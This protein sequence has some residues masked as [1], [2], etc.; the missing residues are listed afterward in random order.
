MMKPLNQE[1]ALEIRYQRSITILLD[2]ALDHNHKQ[3]RIAASVLLSANRALIRPTQEWLVSIP[4]IGL[5]Y[6]R[7]RDAAMGVIHARIALNRYPE[8]V[9]Q[10]GAALFHRLWHRWRNV[11]QWQPEYGFQ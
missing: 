8:T 3:A 2:L 9:I 7:E 4:D 5:L 6:E 10:G 1:T 11:E